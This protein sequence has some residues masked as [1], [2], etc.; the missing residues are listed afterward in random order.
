MA[1]IV[2]TNVESPRYFIECRHK[3]SLGTFCGRVGEYIGHFLAGA[4]ACVFLVVYKYLAVGECRSVRPQ[5]VDY[6]E[7]AVD[8]DT[9]FSQHVAEVLQCRCREQHSVYTH[10]V[11]G[12]ESRA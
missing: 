3:Y 12:F 1:Y 7:M 8:G 5:T 6:I 11:A 9:L 2:A 10:L 4:A